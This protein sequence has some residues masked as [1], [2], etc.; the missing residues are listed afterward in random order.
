MVA[1]N[2]VGMVEEGPVTVEVAK[3]VAADMDVA[4]MVEEEHKEEEDEEPVAE[5]VEAPLP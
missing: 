1:T 4:V 3:E 2:T 5:A